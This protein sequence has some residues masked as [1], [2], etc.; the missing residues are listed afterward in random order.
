M[1][2]DKKLRIGI[3]S[4]FTTTDFI[5]YF[6]EE[7]DRIVLQKA[8]SNVAPSISAL[9]SS[10]LK[11][12]HF[13]RV[14]TLG[15]ISAIVKSPLLE[16]VII[17]KYKNYPGRYI[18]GV[19]NNSRYIYK[20]LSVNYSDLDVLH[21]HWTYEYAY[22][23]GI[24]CHKKIVFCTVRDWAPYIFKFE[25]LKNK[26]TWCFK[27]LIAYKVYKNKNIHF[28]ANS[29]YTAALLEQKLSIK[30]EMIPNSIEDIFFN[31]ISL[32]KDINS[33]LRILCISSSLDSRKNI[34]SLLIAFELVLKKMPSATL[35]LIGPPFVPNNPE[36][37][38]YKLNRNVILEGRIP[39]KELSIYLDRATLF[40]SPSLEETFGN[41]FLEAISR[42]IPVIGGENSGAVPYVLHHG[43]IGW[44]CDVQDPHK[45]SDLILYV[46]QHK[47]E[48]RIKVEKGYQV[49]QS[50]FSENQICQQ[51]INIYSK[52]I[53]VCDNG[54]KI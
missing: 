7:E 35:T 19:F 9:V 28:I 25:K 22:A 42:K 26:V 13:V 18:W 40:V 24:L 36:M 38:K 47:E 12:G 41:T 17:E 31:E 45:L 34:S 2:Y 30:A 43:E 37:S 53:T 20:A 11:E 8:F 32:P 46:H 15:N 23:A 52:H 1:E 33:D 10:F 4:P 54:T 6:E 14:F 49:I 5:D 44:L 16:I 27:L 3:L 50:K 39:H 21:A 48:A 51:H 29:P